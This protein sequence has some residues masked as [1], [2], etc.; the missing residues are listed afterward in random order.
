MTVVQRQPDI[1]LGSWCGKRFHPHKVA[2]R[3]GWQAVP[4]VVNNEVYEIKSAN[5]LQPGPAAL[6]DGLDQL[7]SITSSWRESITST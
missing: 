7:Y 2:Q 5:I 1:I 4:A 3:D 6:S